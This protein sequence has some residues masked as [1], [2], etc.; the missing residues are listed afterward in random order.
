MSSMIKRQVPKTPEIST[1]ITA[2]NPEVKAA[3]ATEAERLRK[4]KGYSS[5]I[6]TGAEGVAGSPATKKETLG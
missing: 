3:A 2:E 4:K 1:P 5:T 6:L